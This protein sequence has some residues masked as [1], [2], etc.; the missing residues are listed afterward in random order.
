MKCLGN[1]QYYGFVEG[2]NP[3]V[4]GGFHSI[5]FV[6]ILYLTSFGQI[7]NYIV[8]IDIEAFFET[9][10]ERIISMWWYLGNENLRNQL[11]NVVP[12]NHF[13]C[14]PFDKDVTMLVRMRNRC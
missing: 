14:E 12:R 5:R 13:D 9:D 3:S 6:F 10:F 7:I 1:Y 4:F 8:M 11:M 2:C